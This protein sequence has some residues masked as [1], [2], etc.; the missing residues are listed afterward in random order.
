MN[1]KAESPA[2][3]AFFEAFADEVEKNAGLMDFA[4]GLATKARSRVKAVPGRA[5]E[6]VGNVP[7]AI[8]RDVLSGKQHSDVLQ[9]FHQKAMANPMAK[10]H[11]KKAVVPEGNVVHDY[12]SDVLQGKKEVPWLEETAGGKGRAAM[13]KLLGRGAKEVGTQQRRMGDARLA[14]GMGITAPVALTAGI[15]NRQMN[16]AAAVKKP[17]STVAEVAPAVAA[18]A[19]ASVPIVQ[20]L[21]SG[22]LGSP[23]ETAKR[24]PDLKELRKNL[25]PG[26]MIMTSSPGKGSVFKAPIAA[27]G[28]DPFGYH[29]ESI[30]S[31]PKGR[32][33]AEFVHASPPHG[34][35][36]R[37]AD[38]LREGED[39]IL[40]RFKDPKA[41]KQYA[42]NIRQRA[43]AQEALEGLVGSHAVQQLYDTKQAL[44]GGAKSFLPG[45]LA[46]LLTRSSP[47]SA[48]AAVCSS[49]PGM[50]SPVCLA[51]GVP[52]KD[53]MPHHIRRSKQLETIGHY[54]AP[55]SFAR[56]SYERLLQGAP[57]LVRGALGAGLGYGAYRAAKA[58]ADR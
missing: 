14:L 48:G 3:V 13:L 8:N 7:S 43:A 6:F 19:G 16:K 39:I 51:P 58:I 38:K 30:S 34:G 41:A 47:S 4:K 37:Y 18:G 45:P 29:I 20:G 40:R 5:R 2:D 24:F 32:A 15:A 11:A 44:R 35:A 9:K 46:R 28:G 52:K 56:G 22:A 50:S 25:R 54:R 23:R 1:N 12:L 33:G 17:K 36:G 57:W 26:D 27:M 31:A 21:Q 10:R 49:L 53:V 42:K 55:R